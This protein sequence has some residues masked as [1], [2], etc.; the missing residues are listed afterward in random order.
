MTHN[1]DADSP[2]VEIRQ[3]A[4]QLRKEL[5]PAEQRL[6]TQLRNRRLAGLKFCRQHPIGRFIVDFYCHAHKLVVEIDG[7]VHEFQEDQDLARAH[8]LQQR[9][10]RVIRF[11]NEHVLED[12]HRVLQSIREACLDERPR[13]SDT[14][15]DEEDEI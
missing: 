12:L 3:R 8:Y 4:R 1:N 2:S 7:P 11:R 5:T 6:S 15:T 13:S 14:R 9:E 10:Y